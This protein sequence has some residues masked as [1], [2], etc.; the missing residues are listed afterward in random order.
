MLSLY[1]KKI[2]RFLIHLPKFF[3]SYLP[4]IVFL[5]F[6]LQLLVAMGSLP[7]LNIIGKY[8]FYVAGILW[9]ISVILFK[10]YITNKRILVLGL[11]ALFVA[12]PFALIQIENVA[13]IMGFAAFLFLLTF[14]IR[15]IF[16]ERKDLS[17]DLK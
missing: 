8:Y 16:I 12:I 13:D 3:K 7:Y 10:E 11:I 6:T 4:H 5:V 2:I 17:N 14:L 15:Q 9:V 1:T